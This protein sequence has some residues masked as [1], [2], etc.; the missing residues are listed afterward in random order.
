MPTWPLPFRALVMEAGEGERAPDERPKPPAPRPLGPLRRRRSTSVNPGVAW[1]ISYAAARRGRQPCRR[2]GQDRAISRPSPPN[3]RS[4]LPVAERA[5]NA[6]IAIAGKASSAGER[7]RRATRRR[8]GR[9][10]S[11]PQPRPALSAA[12]RSRPLSHSSIW[13][14]SRTM[15]VFTRRW[16]DARR[17]VNRPRIVTVIRSVWPPKRLE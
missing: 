7:H 2:G 1:P 17:L 11:T 14:P 13:R 15:R 9:E 6:P 4:S 3:E 5:D 12:Q 8:T 16:P 10:R